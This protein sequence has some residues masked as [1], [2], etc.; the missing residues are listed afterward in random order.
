MSRE[1]RL[2]A[3]GTVARVVLS[4]FS[5]VLYIGA[6]AAPVI[7]LKGEFLP[8]KFTG[9]D[10]LMYGWVPLFTIPWSANI[11]LAVGWIL[12]LCNQNKLALGFG[13]AAT[14]AGLTT[15]AFFQTLLVGYYLWQTSLLALPLSALL[16][17][18]R[19]SRPTCPDPFPTGRRALPASRAGFRAATDCGNAGITAP[20]PIQAGT[21]PPSAIGPGH[22]PR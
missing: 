6:C 1:P 5:G 9:L 4:L 16:M 21:W 19:S 20:T 13:I 8:L 10:A 3:A 2:R 22:G 17:S 15:W 11:F 18:R 14:L 12:L 7:H